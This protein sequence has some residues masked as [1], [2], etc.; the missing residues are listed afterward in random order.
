MNSKSVTIKSILIVCSVILLQACVAIADDAH[1]D[2]QHNSSLAYS[3]VDNPMLAVQNTL[4][5]AKQNNKL[6]LLVLGANWCHDSEGLAK[7]FDTPQM[8]TILS[9]HYETLFIDVGYFEDRRDITQRF[10][11]AHYF[12]TPT[13]LIV[14]PNTEQLLN[15]DT[16]AK[17]GAADS[18]PFDEYLDYFD[19]FDAT[20]SAEPAAISEQHKAQIKQFETQQ[21]KRLMAAYIVL[22]PEL[23]IDAERA[24]GTPY[25]EGFVKRWREVRAY[26][27][28]LQKDILQLYSQA[29]LAKEESLILPVYDTFSWE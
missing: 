1:S 26:R 18:V 25:N 27:I 6:A 4:D 13:V 12:A 7:Q 20:G 23:Q 3:P 9:K 11:Q 15:G 21:S 16:L 14:D 8:Q 19:G 28:Q 10:G 2:N 22:R 5:M 24:K 29:S 17:W